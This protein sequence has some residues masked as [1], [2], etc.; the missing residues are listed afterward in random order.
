MKRPGQGEK[1]YLSGPMTG[2]PDWNFPA[3]NKAAQELR[4]QG[5]TVMNPADNGHERPR[6]ELMRLDFASVLEVNSI[7][8]LPGWDESWGAI[9]EVT[10]GRE[11]GL[12]I[13]TTNFNEIKYVPPLIHAQFLINA[14]RQRDYSHPLDDY[15]RTSGIWNEMLGLDVDAR[16]AML[17]MIGV[18]LSRESHRHTYDNCVDIA[19]YAGCIEKAYREEWRREQKALHEKEEPVPAMQG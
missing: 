11:I 19:G 2:L 10:V 15:T 7:V 5:Y 16:E 9:L 13:Y 18:K 6:T 1:I 8:C 3:F 17:C 12:P 14:D 4:D